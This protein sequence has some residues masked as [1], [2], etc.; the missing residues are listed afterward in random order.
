[1]IIEAL[2]NSRSSPDKDAFPDIFFKSNDWTKASGV[3]EIKKWGQDITPNSTKGQTINYLRKMLNQQGLKKGETFVTNTQ[4]IMFLKQ[5]AD[6]SKAF[7][8]K[9][10]TFLPDLK[11]EKVTEGARGFASFYQRAAANASF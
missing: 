2:V 10:Y 7:Y 3:G 5:E 4:R 8:S 11:F 6:D 9:D 1:M